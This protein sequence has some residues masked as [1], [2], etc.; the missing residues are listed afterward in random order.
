[1]TYE[2]DPLLPMLQAE[3]NKRIDHFRGLSEVE[4]SKLLS[5]TAE[6]RKLIADQDKK[7]KYEYLGT[8][9]NIGNPGVKAHEKYKRFV[10][11][12]NNIQ[13]GEVKA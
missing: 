2:E 5:L 8:A 7:A 11:M 10:D 4:E 9:P 6:Q 1:M 3:M 13:K 12:V